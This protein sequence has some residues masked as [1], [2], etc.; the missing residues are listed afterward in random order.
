M[1]T[2]LGAMLATVAAMATLATFHKEETK[3]EKAS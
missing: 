1:K 2:L 3:D